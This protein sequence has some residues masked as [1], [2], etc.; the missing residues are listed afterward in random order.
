MNQKYFVSENKQIYRL[1]EE[2]PTENPTLIKRKILLDDCIYSSFVDITE[3]A[4]DREATA[5]EIQRF[6]YI[7]ERR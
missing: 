7:L 1:G 3:L 5:E 4:L 6:N 2:S